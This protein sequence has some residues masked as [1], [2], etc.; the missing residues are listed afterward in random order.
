MS[1]TVSVNKTVSAIA[2]VPSS[3]AITLISGYTPLSPKAGARCKL[4][5]PFPLSIRLPNEG[6]L[7]TVMVMA[8]KSGSVDEIPTSNVSPS[9]IF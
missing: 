3:V 9:F 4:P 8:S 7:S 1:F 5:V 2:G 6:K